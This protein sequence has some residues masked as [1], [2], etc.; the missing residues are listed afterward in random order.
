MRDN[1]IL[2]GGP[3]YIDTATPG[4]KSAGPRHQNFFLR[5]AR[6][7]LSG[8]VSDHL[9]RYFQNDFASPPSC[10]FSN[11]PTFNAPGNFVARQ[12]YYY[13]YNQTPG[14]FAYPGWN[15]QGKHGSAPVVRRTPAASRTCSPRRT[16]SRSTAPGL[17]ISAFVPPAR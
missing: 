8:D 3:F 16:A 4:D 13:Y 6:I 10:T 7:I 12:V 9:Y 1:D 17:T 11:T 2:S 5:R 15:Q 14:R